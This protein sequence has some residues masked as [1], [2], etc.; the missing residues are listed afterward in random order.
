MSDTAALLARLAAD[1]AQQDQQRALQRLREWAQVQ[2][3][4][5]RRAGTLRGL[6]ALGT[7]GWAAGLGWAAQL[8]LHGQRAAVTP[9]S[10]LPAACLIAAGLALR[11]WLLAAD[12]RAR[13]RRPPPSGTRCV[14]DCWTPPCPPGGGRP[15]QRNPRVAT[16]PSSRPSTRRWTASPTG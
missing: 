16:P 2:A 10:V 5:F 7:V 4:A 12:D 11:A 13:T 9:V 8:A 15:P 6:G 14:A 3:P 1:D